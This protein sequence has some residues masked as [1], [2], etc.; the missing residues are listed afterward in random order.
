MEE[1]Q[2]TARRNF[3]ES[4]LRHLM[5]PSPLDREK[6]KLRAR[7]RRNLESWLPQVDD[8]APEARGFAA[9]QRIVRR[10]NLIERMSA[11]MAIGS[12]GFKMAQPLE[13]G[14]QR[15]LLREGFA[16]YARPQKPTRLR[17]FLPDDDAASEAAH[18][19]TFGRDKAAQFERV[20]PEAE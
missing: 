6:E 4:L 19:R 8:E 9:A 16:I 18:R 11:A 12:D 14:C 1:Q 20:A 2:G 7:L 5:Q 17:I 10:N 3:T 15:A 13:P